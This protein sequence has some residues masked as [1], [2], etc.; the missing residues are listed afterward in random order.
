MNDDLQVESVGDRLEG[1]TVALCV[2]GGI[3][4]V[5]SVKLIRHFRREGAEVNVF[6][7][8]EALKFIGKAALEWAAAKPVITELSGL[9][10]HICTQDIVVIA[11]ATIN[12]VNAIAAGI[13][14]NVVTT[15]VASA[16]GQKTPV[17]I[18]ATGHH[19]LYENPIFQ[20]NLKELPKVAPAITFIPP[21]MEEGKAKLPELKQIVEASIASF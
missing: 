16:L 9:A 14:G 11:P 4:S 7:T 8:P 13:A 3:A 6:A 15:L 5:E 10:E 19:S 20:R 12:T 17:L 21:K 18:A 2:T 1:K